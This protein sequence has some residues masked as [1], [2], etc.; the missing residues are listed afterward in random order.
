MAR[1]GYTGTEVQST[2][3]FLLSRGYLDDPT[4]ARE[5]ARSRVERKQ[6]GPLRIERRLRELGVEES[7]IEA[8]LSYAF[9]DGQE[10]A[11]IAALA[12]F[13]GSKGQLARGERSRAY[14][15]L[16]SRG[17]T[18]EVAYRLVSGEDLEHTE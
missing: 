17:F 5:L 4:F 1:A 11:A 3:D 10:R 14:R 8:A 6:W 9:P 13:L 12:R 18:G 15:H 7:N 16:L 2:I